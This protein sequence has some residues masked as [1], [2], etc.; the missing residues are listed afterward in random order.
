MLEAEID[1]LHRLAVFTTYCAAGHLWHELCPLMPSA[2]DEPP[3]SEIIRH[4]SSGSET[5]LFWTITTSVT[6]AE[7]SST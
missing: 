3:Q 4:A 7:H 2:G 5:V 1:Q 6:I